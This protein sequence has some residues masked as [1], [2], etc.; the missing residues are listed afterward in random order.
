MEDQREILAK[1]TNTC[2][3]CFI[4]YHKILSHIPIEI[5]HE[6]N[7]LQKFFNEAVAKLEA[8]AERDKIR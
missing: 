3:N 5:L 7:E 1:V 2:T 6:Q 8:S 4:M